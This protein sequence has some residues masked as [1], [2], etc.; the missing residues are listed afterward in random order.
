MSSE[1]VR[2]PVRIDKNLKEQ[3]EKLAKKKNTSLNALALELFEKA[4]SSQDEKVQKQEIETIE[5]NSIIEDKIDFLLQHQQKLKEEIKAEMQ[6]EI[7]EDFKI[8]A[9]VLSR[10]IKQYNT[11]YLQIS[12]PIKFETAQAFAK[13]NKKPFIK[14]N[15]LIALIDVYNQTA[16]L[17]IFQILQ[18]DTYKNIQA[19]NIENE[20]EIIQIDLTNKTHFFSIVQI[21]RKL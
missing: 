15:D 12:K 16:E 8:F 7:L 1:I 14:E 5:R 4:I 2:M 11:G 21:L 10:K 19:K 20:E 6:K 13:E 18:A 9:N 17:K 3:L